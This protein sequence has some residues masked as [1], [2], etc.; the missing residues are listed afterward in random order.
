MWSSA[1]W[2][3]FSSS[4]RWCRSEVSAVQTTSARAASLNDL[5]RHQRAAHVGMH[6]DRIGRLV[7][8]FRAG[9]RAALQALLG[10]GDGVLVGDLGLGEALHADA[11]PR[12][13]HHRE[14]GVE[15][16]VLLAEQPAGGAVVVH[17]AG[18]VAVDAHLLF[19]RAAGHGV[20]RAERAVG[21]R[22]DLRHDEQRNAARALGRAFDA[23]Q[24][25]MDDVGG[26]IVLAGRDEDLGA[27][28]LVAAVR[29]ASPPWCEAAPGPCRNA[30]R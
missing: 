23:R 16:A 17:H 15:P 30:A 4:E 5:M 12:L 29:P 9:E 19:E 8:V 28:D 3:V 24:H 18:R 27:G 2:R 11:E 26:E 10:V 13:V 25:E 14:H 6:D 1:A 22:Q 21:L 7:R 20:A